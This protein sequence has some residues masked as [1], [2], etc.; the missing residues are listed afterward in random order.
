MPNFQR[1]ERHLRRPLSQPVVSL[2][3]KGQFSLN[4]A[5]Y[6]A[7]GHPQAVALLFDPDARIVGIQA[8]G[9]DD[10]NGFRVRRGNPRAEHYVFAAKSF[11]DYYG[12]SLE[13]T[14]R[15]PAELLDG[16]LTIRLEQEPAAMEAGVANARHVGSIA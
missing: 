9:Q 13:E 6:E 4:R 11:A 14:R 3:R 10:L 2:Q 5:A 15:Y 7:L 8:T 12:I 16:T 1:F